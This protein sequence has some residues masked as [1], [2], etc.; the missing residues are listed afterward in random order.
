MEIETLISRQAKDYSDKVFGDK[1]PELKQIVHM[2]LALDPND[3]DDEAIKQ[4]VL[5]KMKR[6][7]IRDSEF[8]KDM[9]FLIHDISGNLIPII[10]DVS[11][12]HGFKFD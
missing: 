4:K 8:L 7:H 10:Y 5:D 12:N 11:I 9:N 6:E 1:D 2:N 3:P